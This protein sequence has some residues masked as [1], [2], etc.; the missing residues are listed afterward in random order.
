MQTLI[1]KIAHHE[2]TAEWVK[3]RQGLAI[4]LT[5][6]IGLDVPQ[7]VILHPWQLRAVCEQF[8][9]VANDGKAQ[10]AIATLERRLRL[11]QY[12]IE[13][14]HEYLAQCSDHDHADLTFEVTYSAATLDMAD[15]FCHGLTGAA[16]GSPPLPFDQSLVQPATK[17]QEPNSRESSAAINQQAIDF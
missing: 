14:L 16:E 5:Q 6:P 2:L 17:K 15:E 7:N 10:Q 9:L 13:A 11:L 1:E 8:G 4:L 12:R 3:D